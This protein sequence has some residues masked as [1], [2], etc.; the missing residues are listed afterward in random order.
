[1]SYVC[2][3]T[4]SI[5]TEVLMRLLFDLK[6]C[7]KAG[8]CKSANSLCGQW[9]RVLSCQS[10]NNTQGLGKGGSR[11]ANIGEAN[12]YATDIIHLEH[13]EAILAVKQAVIDH[14]SGFIQQHHDHCLWY[15]YGHSPV[16]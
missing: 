1:M 7:A 9:V 15:C 8:K 4:L 13:A 16:L 12:L 11:G 10:R 14:V 5:M 3:M 2:E 6:A